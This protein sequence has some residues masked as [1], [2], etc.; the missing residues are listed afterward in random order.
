MQSDPQ[1]FEEI[2]RQYGF[3]TII[4]SHTDQTPWAKAFLVNIVKN[5]DWQTVYIDDFI[6]VLAL[7]SGSL[8]T[9]DLASLDP[10]SYSF[11]SYL[12]YLRLSL[13]LAQTGNM[14]SAQKFAEAGLKLFPE[15]PLGNAMFGIKKENKF[16]W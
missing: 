12:S 16:F 13:F 15:S 2:S 3:K 6:I 11:D 4:F 9:L 5:P 8:Q 14:K 10:V 1:K 7:Q